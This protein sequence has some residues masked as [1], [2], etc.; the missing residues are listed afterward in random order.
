MTSAQN[1]ALSMFGRKK[2]DAL[3]GAFRFSSNGSGVLNVD[4]LEVALRRNGLCP[5][6]KEIREIR[7]RHRD[8]VSLD[9]FLDIAIQCESTSNTYGMSELIDFFAPFD[10]EGQG[11]IREKIFLELML[12]CGERFRQLEIEEVISI[13]RSREHSGFIDYRTFLTS[14]TIV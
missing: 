5:S 2:C 10:L 3:A 13:F 9:Q 12:N 11:L 4:K 7:S 6:L 14:M 8:T 1:R